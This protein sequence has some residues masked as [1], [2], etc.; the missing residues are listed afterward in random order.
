MPHHLTRRFT[1][2]FL[3]AVLLITDPRSTTAQ[4]PRPVDKEHTPTRIL[5]HYMPW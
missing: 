2:A 4:A 1:T 5:A 3:A